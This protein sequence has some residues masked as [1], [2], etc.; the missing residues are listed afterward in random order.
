MNRISWLFGV[1]SLMTISMSAQDLNI[2]P[3]RP[4]IANSAAIQSKGVAQVEVGYDAYPQDPPGNQ[5]TLD[6]LFT[7]SLLPRLRLDF[8][9]SAFNHQQQDGI[10]TN[11]VGTIEIGGKVEAKKEQ[12]HK[13]APGIALQYE[14]ELPTASASPLQGY[15]QQAI[16]LLNHHYGKNGDV[17]VI[18]NGSI[19]QSDCQ[20]TT[21]CRY[22]GQQS[23]ALS[24]HLQKDTRLYAEVFGQ[25]TSQ[26]NTPPGTY[27]FSGFYHQFGDAFGINGGLR[28]GVS[29]HSSTIG[30]TIGLVFGKRLQKDASP[31]Q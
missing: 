12:Y 11:G 8:D 7:Y 10:I 17:D 26:S 9:W 27:V 14:A 21:G 1:L 24:Y 30:T 3:T 6:T 31:R 19:V 13:A 4:T 23:F 15:G 16:L 20:T 29:D 22:G 2:N 18:A 5:Q 25:N 28:F